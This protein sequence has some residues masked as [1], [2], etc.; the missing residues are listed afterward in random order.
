[1]KK[2]LLSVVLIS[3]LSICYGQIDNLCDISESEAKRSQI[4]SFSQSTNKTPLT[5]NY[6]LKYH[7][8]DLVVDPN[9]Q[10]INGAL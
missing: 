2:L 4:N 5:N 3:L 8:L 10:Y 9:I 6:D 7:R 1:M